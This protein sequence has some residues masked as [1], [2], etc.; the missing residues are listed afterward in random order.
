MSHTS[1]SVVKR[2]TARDFRI[3]A[4][5]VLLSLVPTLGGVMRMMNLSGEAAVRPEN[6]RFAA[7]PIPIVIHIISATLYSLLGAFQFARAFRLRWP[8]WHRRAGRVLVVAGLLAAGT[9]LWMTVFYPIPADLQGPITYGVRL[10]VGSAML[11]AIVLALS[12]ILRRD[13]A[14]HEAFMIR[15]YA[16]AQ[17]A[18]TQ[19]VILGPWTVIT[20]QSGGFTRDLLLTLSWAINLAVAEL[21]IWS[22]RRSPRPARRSPVFF[23][24]VWTRWRSRG[25]QET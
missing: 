7:A 21:I 10:V 14:R 19:A 3:P 13:V 24:A 25:I 6:V 17:G 22:R 20:G 16:L 18:G 11:A 2:L 4:L 23:R 9:G 15:A 1:K 5:L 8:R 12:S